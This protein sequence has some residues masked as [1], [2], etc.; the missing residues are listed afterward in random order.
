MD[1]HIEQRV[2]L[3]CGAGSGLGQAIALSLAQEGVKV[4]VTGRSPDKLAQTVELIARAGGTAQA[5]TLD[6]A[7]PHKFDSVLASIRECWGD[8]DILINNSGGPPPATA[9]GTDA[10][11]WQQQFSLMVGSLIQLSD[12][13]LPAMRKRGW[14]RIITS[15]SSG[16]ISPIPNLALSNALR[17]SLLGWS[18]TLA[19]EVAADGVTVNIMVPGRIA[20]DRV[21]QLDAIKVKRENTSPDDVAEKSRQSIPLGRYGL[22]EEYGATAAFLA[23]VPA[24]YI[25][26]AVIRVD[27]GLISS[28]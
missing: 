21:S 23:G 5:W 18:K 2:A 6:L 20:T 7:A 9:Q 28:V 26:G 25:T 1:L 8:I 4:A 16:V 13:V 24:G 11:V 17:M 19:S 3:V 27:G 12:K 14:G 22:P 15:T 10:E